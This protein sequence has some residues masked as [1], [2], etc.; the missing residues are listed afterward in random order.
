LNPGS[1]KLGL[2]ANQGK[3]ERC[4]R[5]GYGKYVRADIF[6]VDPVLSFEVSSK[7]LLIGLIQEQKPGQNDLEQAIP[8]KINMMSLKL[9]NRNNM[10]CHVFFKRCVLKNTWG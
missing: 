8:I 7:N 3:Y 4:K 9:V 2:Q 1:T 5:Y 10:G 6:H